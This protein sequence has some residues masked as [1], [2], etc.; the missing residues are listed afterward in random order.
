MVN[1]RKYYG[2]NTKKLFWISRVALLID[3]IGI[4]FPT[5]STNK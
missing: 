5:N 4:N 2:F 3:Q 1:D